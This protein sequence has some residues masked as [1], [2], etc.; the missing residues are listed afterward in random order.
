MRVPVYP[1]DL[2]RNRGFKS[3]AK[4]LQTHWCGPSSVSLS[5]AQEV[6]AKGL[7][8]RDYHDLEQ[9]SK[10]CK[11]DELPPSEAD[12]RQAI[13]SAI[14][15]ARGYVVEA[16]LTKLELLV[17]ALPISSLVAFNLMQVARDIIQGIQDTRLVSTLTAEHLRSVERVIEVSGNLRDQAL[18]ACMLAGVR[19]GEFLSATVR[20]G[21]AVYRVK[22]AD[23]DTCESLPSSC[24]AAVDKYLKGSSVSEG[25]YLFPST[26]DP[27]SPMSPLTLSRIC[28]SWAHKAG[29]EAGLL[30]PHNV[31]RVGQDLAS[32]IASLLG[33]TSQMSTWAYIGDSLKHQSR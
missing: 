13:K 25:G 8:Y 3:L 26:Y 17:D 16:D 24:G 9:A 1:D 12:A 4:K 7:G 5:F 21:T 19:R 28:A 32:R 6:L 31:R 10:A 15:N 27:K 14:Q 30:K 11:L 29:I 20:G 22:Y 2:K 33:H 23:I 18:F